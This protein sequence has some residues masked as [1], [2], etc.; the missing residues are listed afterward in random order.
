[1]DVEVRHLRCF[2]A[3]A[4]T[5]HFGRAAEQLHLAQPAVSKSVRQLEREL[6]VDLLVR[7]TRSVSLT[8][9]G[10]EY[11]DRARGVT[12]RLAEAAVAARA[13][14]DGRSG[15]LRLGVTGS[16]TFGF[17]PALARAAATA[18]P[19]VSL[20][21][22]TEMLTPEQE[23]ALLDDQLDVGVLRLPTGSPDL[24]HV[25]VA[26]ERLVAALPAG[27]P[28]A[29][30]EGALPLAELADATFITYADRTGSV[31]LRAVLDACQDAGFVPRRAHEVTETSTT[32]A[33]VA[34]GLGVALV[35]ESAA[36]LTLDGVVFRPVD[37]HRR[38]DLAL[39]WAAG[40]PRPV[41]TRLVE[42]LHAHDL[43]PR[44]PSAPPTPVEE[45]L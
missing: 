2:L 41:V 28:S 5:L 40:R 24:E 38:L 11:A 45:T 14:A 20:Q 1:M 12:A 19:D 39:A 30:G 17:L 36:A 16:A 18:M 13:T 29:G 27:H 25:V 21:V 43:I 34:A 42:A 7:T 6:G 9:A 8:P 22:R 32:V 35:P 3:V 4:D 15:T 10:A 44:D 37:S 31:V 23:R 33:L 26:R